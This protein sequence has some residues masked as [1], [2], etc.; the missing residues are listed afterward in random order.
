MTPTEPFVLDLTSTSTSTSTSSSTEP[1]I[2]D[3]YSGVGGDL[4][5][6]LLD[7]LEPDETLDAF[8]RFDESWTGGVRERVVADDYGFEGVEAFARA[9][10]RRRRA[11]LVC[12]ASAALPPT[13]SEVATSGSART[14]LAIVALGIAT[15]LLAVVAFVG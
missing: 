8:V 13:L 2:L 6:V 4:P 1:E 14:P 9:L 15:A 3:L 12:A 7:E 10:P 5:I 11:P